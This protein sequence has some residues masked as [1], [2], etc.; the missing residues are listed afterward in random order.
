M[1]HIE[2]AKQLSDK[3]DKATDLEKMRIEDSLRQMKT[4]EA[5]LR[6]TYDAIHLKFR[7]WK[8]QHANEIA[9]PEDDAQIQQWTQQRL[10]LISRVPGLAY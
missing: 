2:K 1:A 9:K 6:K 7:T 3:R 8:E 10:A 4:A 5:Q